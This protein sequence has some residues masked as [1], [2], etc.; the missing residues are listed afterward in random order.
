M[1]LTENQR[2]ELVK[3]FTELE[4][5]TQRQSQTT[6]D[7]LQIN[8][9]P[10][11]KPINAQASSPFKNQS[12]SIASPSRDR[13]RRL[14]NEKV[15]KNNKSFWSSGVENSANS[16]MMSKDNVKTKEEKSKMFG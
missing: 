1:V 6:D 4:R 3:E 2:D 7:D 9:R 8:E 5:V 15:Q 10:S 16:P 12:D 13:H 14:M 11:N